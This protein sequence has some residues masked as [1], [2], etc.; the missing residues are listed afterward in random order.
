VQDIFDRREAAL[1]GG[2]EAAGKKKA[3]WEAVFTCKTLVFAAQ[4]VFR[5]HLTHLCAE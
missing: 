1:H 4:K 5:R 2:R 3:E